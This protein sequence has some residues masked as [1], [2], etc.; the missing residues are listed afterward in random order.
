MLLAKQRHG[1]EVCLD[2]IDFLKQE[3]NA[4]LESKNITQKAELTL[5]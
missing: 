1:L 2:E 5:H 4:A 3:Q